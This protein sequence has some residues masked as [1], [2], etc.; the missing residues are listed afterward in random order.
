MK[1]LDKIWLDREITKATKQRLVK[2]LVFHIAIYGCEAWTKRKYQ[3]AK[4]TA[5]EMWCW[6][7]MLRIPWTAK[8]TKKDIR[9]QV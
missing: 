3:L 9:N 7:R 6:C 5:F 1:G 4:I 2:A 8:V